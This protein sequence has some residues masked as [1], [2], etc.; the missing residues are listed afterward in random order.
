VPVVLTGL[1]EAVDN[2][3]R[4]GAL[5]DGKV[6]RA[7]VKEA[8]TSVL[9]QAQASAPSGV[10]KHRLYTGE[11]A[12][13]GYARQHIVLTTG[14]TKDKQRA[15]AAVGPTKAAY[16]VAQYVEFGHFTRAGTASGT[17]G[18]RN[19]RDNRK[20][21]KE[22]DDWIPPHPWLRPAFYQNLERIESALGGSFVQFFNTIKPSW[23]A[24]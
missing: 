19:R 6:L 16:Y 21:K 14:M 18:Q 12:Y 1:K 22:G 13:P 11:L 8:M 23:S 9:L 5:D 3:K 4:I 10:T 24:L 7:G 20:R 17:G 2:L 15:F